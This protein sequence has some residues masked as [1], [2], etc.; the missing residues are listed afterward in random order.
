LYLCL[1]FV[2]KTEKQ[3]RE[4]YDQEEK[5]KARP[6]WVPDS[7]QENCFDCGQDFSATHR[8][9][10]CRNCGNIFCAGMF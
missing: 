7:E 4:L 8:R 6:R 3:M 2:F 5:K 9:H 1:I 10:H